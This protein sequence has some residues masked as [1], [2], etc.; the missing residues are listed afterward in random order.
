MKKSGKCKREHMKKERQR[1]KG[2]NDEK[3]A[4]EKTRCEEKSERWKR[5]NMK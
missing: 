5:E 2:D 3:Q 1:G 4:K